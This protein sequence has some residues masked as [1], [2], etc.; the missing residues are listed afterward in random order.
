MTARPV[1][2]QDAGIVVPKKVCSAKFRGDPVGRLTEPVLLEKKM[3]SDDENPLSDGA[4]GDP[5]VISHEESERR[6]SFT[7][8]FP[9][10]TSMSTSMNCL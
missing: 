1:R 2:L 6:P 4:S 3:D 9:M 10:R 7:F 8:R 5:T